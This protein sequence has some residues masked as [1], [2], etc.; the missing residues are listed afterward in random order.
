MTN[1]DDRILY[2]SE[3]SHS[4]V[5]VTYRPEGAR[6]KPRCVVFDLAHVPDPEAW[7]IRQPPA[8][9]FSLDLPAEPPR[10]MQTVSP[11]SPADSGGD[12]TRSRRVHG[13]ARCAR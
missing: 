5:E 4:S 9:G 8:R 12:G 13:C 11:N 6:E 10:A 7:L 1:G 2:N 3:M